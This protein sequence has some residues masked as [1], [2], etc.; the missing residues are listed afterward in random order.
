MLIGL[1]LRAKFIDD[2]LENRSHIDFSGKFRRIPGTILKLICKEDT[3]R[4]QTIERSRLQTHLQ[5]VGLKVESNL[6][7]AP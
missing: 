4:L 2:L 6:A 7:A 5:F 1:I 3:P